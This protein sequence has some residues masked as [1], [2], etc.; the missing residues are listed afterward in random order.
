V[1]RNLQQHSC[2]GITQI[3]QQLEELNVMMINMMQ[4]MSEMESATAMSTA[5]AQ[6]P[7]PARIRKKN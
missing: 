2:N 4:G 3:Q 7:S 5:I 1:S 6:Q